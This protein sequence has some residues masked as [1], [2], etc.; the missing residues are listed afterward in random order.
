M[1]RHLPLFLLALLLLAIPSKANIY[2]EYYE[3]LNEYFE[4]LQEFYL[5]IKSHYQAGPGAN[6]EKVVTERHQIH[7]PEHKVTKGGQIDIKED[8]DGDDIA[9]TEMPQGDES[10][11]GK[12]NQ[13]ERPQGGTDEGLSEE[14]KELLKLHNVYRRRVANGEVPG[15]PASSKIHDLVS[16]PSHMPS[17]HKM[18]LAEGVGKLSN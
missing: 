10:D 11:N 5:I 15:H 8:E 13:H 7:E 4:K 9:L 2:E 3:K 14:K 12:T 16:M 17:H 1:P 18:E 6:P